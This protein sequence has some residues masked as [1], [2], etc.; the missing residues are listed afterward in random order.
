[1]DFLNKTSQHPTFLTWFLNHHSTVIRFADHLL[2]WILIFKFY[3]IVTTFSKGSRP[4]LPFLIIFGSAKEIFVE[5]SKGPPYLHLLGEKSFYRGRG[6]RMSFS[7]IYM[8]FP[9]IWPKMVHFWVG[10]VQLFERWCTTLVK[11]KSSEKN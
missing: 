3:F 10:V 7:V 4:P 8:F 9:R 11:K 6:F 1:M 5:F 2:V